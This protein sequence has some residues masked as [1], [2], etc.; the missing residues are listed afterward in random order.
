[1]CEVKLNNI[2]VNG[3]KFPVVT[4]PKWVAAVLSALLSACIMRSS[5][6][7]TLRRGHGSIITRTF[8]GMC[9]EL[10]VCFW[11]KKMGFNS[12]MAFPRLG[13][14]EG[15]DVML[16][17]DQKGLPIQVKGSLFTDGRWIERLR[18]G[19]RF[20]VSVGKRD[21][22]KLYAWGILHPKSIEATAHDVHVGIVTVLPGVTLLDRRS[23]FGIKFGEIKNIEPSC[24]P[25]IF[26][27]SNLEQ[28]AGDCEPVTI[29]EPSSPKPAGLIRTL[30]DGLNLMSVGTRQRFLVDVLLDMDLMRHTTRLLAREQILHF[31]PGYDNAEHIRS[32]YVCND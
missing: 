25:D 16:H 10:A 1:M 11:F 29:P 5:R 2:A 15:W 7:G 8:T 12:T 3:W 32:E 31:G 4:Y 20:R 23:N 14:D 6:L 22:L 28:L 18:L 30:V 21:E 19:D 27:S 24:A 13:P 26:V 17:A 9:A